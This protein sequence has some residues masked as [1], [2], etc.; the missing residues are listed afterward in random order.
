MQG[1]Q[2]PKGMSRIVVALDSPSLDE[3]AKVAATLPK[4]V[5]V[6]VGTQLLYERGIS[7]AVRLV[8]TPGG[9]V[10]VDLKLHDT[11]DTM[12]KTVGNIMTKCP[13]IDYINLHASAGVEGMR[14]AVANKGNAKVLA[15]TVLTSLSDAECIRIYGK[16]VKEKV[17]EFALDALEAGCDGLIGSPQEAEMLR[18][19]PRLSNMEIWTPGTRSDW[20]QKNDQ[21]R[22]ATPAEA[23]RNGADCVIIGRPIT[24]PPKEIG[25]PAEAVA[26]IA[27]EIDEA[28]N[29]DEEV[30]A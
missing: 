17:M 21:K 11:K 26:K 5:A 8:R 12:G 14:A 2:I 25:T 19:E 10:F 15:V 23:I 4:G 18:E 24:D 6:K 22:T 9:Q 28:S 16:P 1:N 27:E 20:A 13:D 29:P 3:A 7:E 30:S